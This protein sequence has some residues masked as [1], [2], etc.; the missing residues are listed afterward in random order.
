MTNR[1]FGYLP[2][3]DRMRSLHFN[4]ARPLK[5]SLNGPHGFGGVLLTTALLQV[6]HRTLFALGFATMTNRCDDL[7][8]APVELGNRQ[9]GLW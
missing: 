2:E 6:H 4:P 8:E 1:K 7:A 5:I 3:I 9:L